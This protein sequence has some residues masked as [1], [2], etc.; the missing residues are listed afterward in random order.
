MPRHACAISPIFRSAVFGCV[1][2]TCTHLSRIREGGEVGRLRHRRSGAA[3]LV[4]RK[5]VGGSCKDGQWVVDTP[6]GLGGGAP[7]GPREQCLSYQTGRRSRLNSL[8]A[9]GGLV[10]SS[11]PWIFW[12]IHSFSTPLEDPLDFCS[13]GTWSP[14]SFPPPDLVLGAG[15]PRMLSQ[16]GCCFGFEKP[17]CRAP[18]RQREPASLLCASAC[19]PGLRFASPAPVRA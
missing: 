10:P 2:L 4:P 9:T 14:S 19:M 3:Q 17:H 8:A 1:D 16:S 13:L 12:P 7:G 15:T 11:T 6:S 5:G 18:G